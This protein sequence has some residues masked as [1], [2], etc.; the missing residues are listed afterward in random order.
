MQKLNLIILLVASINALSREIF[1]LTYDWRTINLIN[2]NDKK[3]KITYQMSSVLLNNFP[4]FAKQNQGY[5]VN[6]IWSR[7]YGAFLKSLVDKTWFDKMQI[8]NC[9]LKIIW[10]NKVRVS[11]CISR[12]RNQNYGVTSHQLNF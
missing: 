10:V 6:M 3:K 5:F 7:S 4:Y 1:L 2:A 9:E 8:A 12:V 11:S